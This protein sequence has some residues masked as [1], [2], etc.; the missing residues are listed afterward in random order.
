MDSEHIR[1][2]TTAMNMWQDI[3]VVFDA[4]YNDANEWCNLQGDENY[5][6]NPLKFD[7]NLKEKQDGRIIC[8]GRMW[9]KKNVK[10]ELWKEDSSPCKIDMSFEH[11][12]P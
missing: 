10:E 5:Q 8:R 6:G 3:S 1:F 2:V 9:K 11:S 4:C 7:E 12:S